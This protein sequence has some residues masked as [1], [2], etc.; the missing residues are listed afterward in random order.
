MPLQ[1]IAENAI[2][3]IRNTVSPPLSDGDIK[4]VSKI[5]DQAIIDAA[6]RTSKSYRN[7]VA[8]NSDPEDDLAHKI[9]KKIKLK[10]TALI[11]NLIGLR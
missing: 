1:K 11:A 6:V 10:E 9:A 4:K 7:V 3:Q 2:E 5:I 8:N